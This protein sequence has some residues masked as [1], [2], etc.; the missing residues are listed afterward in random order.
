MADLT[1]DESDA[2]AH[3]SAFGQPGSIPA[4]RYVPTPE[5]LAKITPFVM[6]VSGDWRYDLDTAQTTAL[7]RGSRAE[8][9]E[10]KWNIWSDDPTDAGAT[11]VYFCRSWTGKLIV[12]AEI[13]LLDAGSRVT[14]ATW[15]MDGAAVKDPSESFAREQFE[16]CCAWVLGMTRPVPSRPGQFPG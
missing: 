1:D 15:E 7:L 2:L 5:D 9:M 4:T 14:S 10:D 8:Q 13:Q 6:P 12:R 16:E 11:S 3:W